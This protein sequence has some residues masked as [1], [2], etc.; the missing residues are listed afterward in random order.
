MVE[1]C[2]NLAGLDERHAVFVSSGQKWSRV[3]RNVATSRGFPD[4]W[5]KIDQQAVG[6]GQVNGILVITSV[7]WFSSEVAETTA[8]SLLEERQSEGAV[9]RSLGALRRIQRGTSRIEYSRIFADAAA[10]MFQNFN[11]GRKLLE[12][13]GNCVSGPWVYA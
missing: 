6:C 3:A 7:N 11:K 2:D 4:W 10:V 12:V 9:T 1:T 5:F 8:V 13:N